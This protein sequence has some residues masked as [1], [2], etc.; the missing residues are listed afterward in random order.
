MDKAIKKR[1]KAIARE[2][3]TMCDE[4]VNSITVHADTCD[5]MSFLHL[6]V[7]G[8]DSDEPLC[9]WHEFPENKE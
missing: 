4:D 1:L 3:L 2:L 5:K 6:C 7:Y 8:P 9:S